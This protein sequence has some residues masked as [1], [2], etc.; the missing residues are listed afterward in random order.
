[1][2]GTHTIRAGAT[3]TAPDVAR[4]AAAC[5]G[6]DAASLE[7]FTLT[8]NWTFRVTQKGRSPMV[9]RVYRPGGR[10]AVEIQSELA[11]M[12]ALRADLGPLVPDVVGDRDGAHLVEVTRDGDLPT[13]YCVAFSLAPGR[14]PDE[15]ALGAWFPRLGAITARFHQHARRWTPP[16]WFTRPTWNVD[17]TLG[18]QPHWGPWHSSVPDAAERVQLQRLADVVTRRLEAFG[19]DPARFGL[20]HADL[21]LANLIADDGAIQVI[22][23]DDCGFSWFLYDLACALT[24]NEGRADVDDLVAGWV[25]GYRQVEPLSEADAA[26][27]PTFLML[28]RLVLS[29]YVGLRRDTEMAHDLAKDGYASQSCVLAERYLSRFA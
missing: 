2:L 19:T 20:V 7:Q 8:E 21:R 23:F 10:P 6:Y 25:S 18:Q 28:R 22:D 13:C 15:D 12:R 11:W 9:I 5:Y 14:E 16:A 29:A 27:I 24:F 17:T 3:S 26:E 4:L 1:M